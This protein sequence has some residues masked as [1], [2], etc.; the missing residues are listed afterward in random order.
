MSKIILIVGASGSGKTTASLYLEEYHN[1]KTIVS[2]T[3]RP[4]RD[5]EVNGREHWFVNQSEV[6]PYDTMSAYTK[7]G[8]YEYWTCDS[9]FESSDV[10]L[11]YVIDEKGVLF[12][13]EHNRCNMHDIMIVKVVRDNLDEIDA[14]RKQRDE[15]RVQLP[16]GYYDATIY[17]NGTLQDFYKQLD[18]FYTNYINK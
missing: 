10:P 14:A 3:T 11:I 4:M 16:H 1:C 15:D 12:F 8:D 13:L 7:F 6:P 9:Q 18:E 5:G 2:Y 17:N